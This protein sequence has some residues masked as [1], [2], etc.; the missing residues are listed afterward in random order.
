MSLNIRTYQEILLESP[1]EN[2]PYSELLQTTE[3][4]E[5]REVIIKRDRMNCQNCFNK[6]YQKF[7]L[8]LIFGTDV[9]HGTFNS[10]FHEDG[11]FIA[12]VWDF[13]NGNIETGFVHE[14]NFSIEKSSIAYYK[15]NGNYAQIIALKLIENSLI[16]L[17]SNVEIALL[18]GIKG[19]V[20]EETFD[21][22]YAPIQKDDKWR[23]IYGLHVHHKYYQE[24]QLPWG[25][26]DN[27]L[28][29]L[30]WECHEKL[31]HESTVPFL[32]FQGIEIG[33]YT[34]C[35]RCHGAGIF[36]EYYHVESGICFR[37]GGARFE[38]LI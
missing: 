25:Y 12:R 20:K 2:I 27:A 24:G 3:W 31:H 7:D 14:K 18:G 8:G 16:K 17:N 26:P 10:K 35:Y 21:M 11:Y 19:K 4:R 5:K 29:T 9:P 23:I 37:C 15:K 1:D 34:N 13:K 32:D 33:K 36:P 28:V 22:V 30:C 38:E 6:S